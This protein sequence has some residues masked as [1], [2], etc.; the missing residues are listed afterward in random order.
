MLGAISRDLIF[1]KRDAPELPETPGGV[2]HYAGLAFARLGAQ[3]RVV[4]RAAAADQSGLLAPLRAAGVVV[5]CLPSACTTCYAN[6]YS[7]EVDRHR[8]L[9]VSDQIRAEDVPADW[10][11]A[12][13]V[14][15]GP[16]HREDLHPDVAAECRGL[17]G[18]DVQGLVR[19][20]TEHATRLAPHPELPRYLE[21]VDV[22]QASETELPALLDG[23]TL[24]RFVRRFDVRE[25]LITR[26]IRGATVIAGGHE[27]HVSAAPVQGGFKIGAGDVFLAAYLFLRARGGHD[28]VEAGQAAAAICGARIRTGEVPVTPAP[29][30]L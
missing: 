29:E 22:L 11:A 13:C 20:Q 10:R 7:G 5:R 26:G 19:L 8:L 25:M 24:E 16:L 23:D 6:D 12:A 1:R 15:L 9:S 4:T 28:P 17:R 27:K 3:T 18:L 14:Q 21:H 30:D 2:V